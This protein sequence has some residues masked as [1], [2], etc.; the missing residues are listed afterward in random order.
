MGTVHTELEAAKQTI[1][2]IKEVQEEIRALQSKTFDQ[3]V[4]L[5]GQ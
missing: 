1:D 4:L 3:D 2:N 5:P